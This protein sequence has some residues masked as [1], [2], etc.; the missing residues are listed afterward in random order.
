MFDSNKVSKILRWILVILSGLS[1]VFG[2]VF[3]LIILIAGGG[4][5]TPKSTAILA[6]LLGVFYC[7]FFLLVSEV[8]RLLI[9]VEENTRIKDSGDM[10]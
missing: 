6:L 10:P 8:L 3:T 5:E 2:V 7:V 9:R 1:L 4:P